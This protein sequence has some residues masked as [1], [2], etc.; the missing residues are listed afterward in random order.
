MKSPARPYGVFICQF[1]MILLLFANTTNVGS[2]AKNPLSKQITLFES[3]LI[4]RNFV[5]QYRMLH[6]R[7]SH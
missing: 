2:T 3:L 1:F 5:F 7:E 6:K 4:F